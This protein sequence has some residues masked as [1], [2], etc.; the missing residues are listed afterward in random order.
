MVQ[1]PSGAARPQGDNS[2]LL[3]TLVLVPLTLFLVP[4]VV[5]QFECNV[6]NGAG[7]GR[8]SCRTP[9]T[10]HRFSEL[11]IQGRLDRISP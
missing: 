2:R 11:V 10:D 9:D 5:A 3:L 4:L 7:L 1:P 8:T 6:E